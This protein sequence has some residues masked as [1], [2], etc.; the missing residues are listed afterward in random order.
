M[1]WRIWPPSE[2]DLLEFY[3]DMKWK[4]FQS[5]ADLSRSLFFVHAIKRD[6]VIVKR[7]CASMQTHIWI[8]SLSWPAQFPHLSQLSSTLMAEPGEPYRTHHMLLPVIGSLG[9]SLLTLSLN[10]NVKRRQPD[11]ACTLLHVQ[12]NM[13]KHKHSHTCRNT[14]CTR[15][16]VD[17]CKYSDASTKHE[18]RLSVHLTLFF[19]R[20]NKLKE[21]QTY[22][23][24]F[25]FSK[26]HF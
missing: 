26:A 7:L 17:T 24:K 16:H 2:V 14:S 11:A 15:V 23:K 21:A 13:C 25:H 10:G 1:L 5:P 3:N 6:R 22:Q 20:K 9:A 12:T 4:K 18:S 8:F 19:F